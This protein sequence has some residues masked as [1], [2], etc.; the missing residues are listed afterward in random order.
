MTMFNSAAA[1]A[2]RL[3]RIA[4]S[5]FAKARSISSRVKTSA[6]TASTS[7]LGTVSGAVPEFVIAGGTSVA[8]GSAFGGVSL[9]PLYTHTPIAITAIIAAAAMPIILGFAN[10]EPSLLSV[11]AAGAAPMSTCTFFVALRVLIFSPMLLT[12]PV[13]VSAKLVSSPSNAVD[14]LSFAND[15]LISTGCSIGLAC[16]L[17]FVP[18][19]GTA[20]ALGFA[21]GFGLA[22]GFRRLA[23]WGFGAAGVSS[24]LNLNADSGASR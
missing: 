17:V 13:I 20:F 10:G 2:L 3:S 1:S 6:L 19:F 5:A 11:F 8:T 7:V 16:S 4:A 14:N 18:G 15:G 12:M 22:A 23:T 24:A 21:S 9:D